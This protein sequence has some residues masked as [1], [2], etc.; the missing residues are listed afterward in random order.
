MADKT[1]AGSARSSIFAT[2]L[3]MVLVPIG[4]IGLGLWQLHRGA[5]TMRDQAQAAAVLPGLIE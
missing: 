2:I 4:L 5:E 3:W 1:I